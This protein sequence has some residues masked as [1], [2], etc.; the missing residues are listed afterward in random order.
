MKAF[1]SY[2]GIWIVSLLL[3]NVIAFV[4]P[5]E[6][7]GGFWTGYIFITLAFLGQL[8]C[9][10]IAFRSP[11]AQKFFYNFS[12][13]SISYISTLVML[14]VGGLAMALPF[15]PIWLGVILCILV[16]GFSAIAI[17]GALT[18]SQTVSDID[19]K[20][21]TKTLF[22]KMLTADAETLMQKASSK[23]R[24]ITKKV[25]EAIRYSDPVS[26]DA[27]SMI[28]SQITLKFKEFENAVCI[29][30]EKTESL[31][32]ELLILVSDRNTKCKLLK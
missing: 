9:S 23:E 3:F 13:I 6:M 24:D 5:I 26:I 30:S 28:E 15:V 7:N 10:R 2:L 22:I 12:L 31:G 14:A 25:Y 21:K 18:T 11:N 1:K 29:Q 17:I 27:L 19:A 8:L 20:I 4:S 32:K 16:L